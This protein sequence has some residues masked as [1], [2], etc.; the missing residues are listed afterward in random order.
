MI[1]QF[2]DIQPGFTWL[3]VNFW[4]NFK[5]CNIYAALKIVKLWNTSQI[6]IGETFLEAILQIIESWVEPFQA[7]GL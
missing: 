6:L 2:C 7:H 3:R 5:A 1:N 4:V